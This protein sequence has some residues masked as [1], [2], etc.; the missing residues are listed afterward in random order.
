LQQAVT[1]KG[2]GRHRSADAERFRRLLLIAAAACVP[3]VIAQLALA[4]FVTP[5]FA[6][7]YAEAGVGRL[8]ALSRL[9]FQLSEGPWLVLLMLAV[10]AAVFAVA[11]LIARRSTPW[12]LFAPAVIF[13]MAAGS[14][15][16]WL[17]QPLFQIMNVVR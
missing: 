17:Y 3:F 13:A 15:V 11:Y 16:P 14:F 8:P 10:D 5:L 6:D 2:S 9:V 7:M 4:V 1:D 12:V